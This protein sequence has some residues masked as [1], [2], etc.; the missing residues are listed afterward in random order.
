MDLYPLKFTPIYKEKVWGGESWEIAD[1]GADVSLV[2]EGPLAGRSLRALIVEHPEG[3][4]GCAIAAR[5][6][7][8]FPLLL[9]A[10]DASGNLSVQVHP[11]DG[12]AAGHEKGEWGKTELWYV[13]A[14]DEGAEMLCG[15]RDGVGRGELV[16]ALA[17]DRVPG[18]LRRIGV[19]AGDALL[20]PAGR[21][22]AVCAGARVIEI[23]ENSDVTYRLY[24]WGRDGRPMHR[25][26][27]IEVI[28]FEDRS[29][30]RIEKR[31]ERGD[32][33]RRAPL[34]RCRYFATDLVEVEGRLRSACEGDRFRVLSVASGGGIL[35]HGGPGGETGLRGGDHLLLPAGLGGYTIEAARGGCAL[36]QT[37]V[38]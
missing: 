21:I 33:F 24:D 11:P 2:A 26:K 34:A 6:L 20:V 29:D 8:R 5:R 16:Q 36:L 31:W 32:G 15:L 10:L 23:E 13:A 37:E 27:A 14:A 25:E 9:K 30:P 17:E 12:Y 38:P 4:L 1:H 19:K 7:D 22:H 28:D 18:C 35:R 3:I